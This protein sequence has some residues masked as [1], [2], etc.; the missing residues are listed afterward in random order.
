LA[1]VKSWQYRYYQAGQNHCQDDLQKLLAARARNGESGDAP[2]CGD[3][4]TAP[5]SKGSFVIF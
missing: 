2:Y 1:T 3:S 4:P 5:P